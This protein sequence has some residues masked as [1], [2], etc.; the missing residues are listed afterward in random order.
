MLNPFPS[1]CSAYLNCNH[2]NNLD[3][4]QILSASPELFISA[5]DSKLFSS[6]IKGTIPRPPTLKQ[7]QAALESLKHSEKDQAEL[8]MIVDLIRNDLGRISEID[9]VRVLSHARS[10]SLPNVH[11]LVS[12]ICCSRKSSVSFVDLIKALFPGGSITGAPKIAAMKFISELEQSKRGIFTGSIG[13]LGPNGL[14]HFN[15]AIR[16]ALLIKQRLHFNAGAG[17]VIDSDPE[18]EYEE[19]LAKASGIFNAWETASIS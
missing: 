12:D 7:D 19:T 9:S 16:T 1:A 4:F 2:S 11:H 18:L 15:I 6:P 8:A 5:K 3:N 13:H 14:L 17:I 10:F